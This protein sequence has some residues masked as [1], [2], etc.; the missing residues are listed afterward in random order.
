V[1]GK[2]ASRRTLYRATERGLVAPVLEWLGRHPDREW[3][4]YS[5]YRQPLAPP[6]RCCFLIGSGN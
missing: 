6:L 2:R 3:D 4:F 5:D 1:E